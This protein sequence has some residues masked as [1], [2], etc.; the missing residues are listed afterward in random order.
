M[1][2]VPITPRSFRQ[3]PGDHQALLQEHDLEPRYP[4]VDRLLDEDEMIALV[5]GCRAVIVGLDPVTDAVMAAGP[6]SIIVKYGSGLDNVD[7]AAA[8]RRGVRVVATPGMNAPSV[9]EL[10][11]AFMFALARRIVPHHLAMRD[12]S[13]MRQLGL[14]L[15]GRSLGIIGY[16]NIGRRVAGIG[17]CIGMEV[18]VHDPYVAQ[19]E[20]QTG[21]LDR[22]LA[23][24]VVSVH[25]PH[26]EATHHLIA[27]RELATMGPAALLIN[28]SRPPVVDLAALAEA[29]DEGRIGGAA[30]DDLAGDQGIMARLLT[31]DRFLATPH[32][33]AATLDGSVRTGVATVRALLEHRS[34]WDG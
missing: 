10:T 15:G 14:E 22:I 8:E 20:F 18:L 31:S 23:C 30:F 1:T 24:D 12:G 11:I 4:G 32:C 2:V 21:D 3:V 9:A 28:T 7:L 29:L 5:S 6:L 25:V 33:G 19:H 13:R 17:R 16:G 34:L 26:D 27:R